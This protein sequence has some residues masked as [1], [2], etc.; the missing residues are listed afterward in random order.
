MARNRNYPPTTIYKIHDYETDRI[1]LDRAKAAEKAEKRR[2][3]KR[4]PKTDAS[5]TDTE[6]RM[7][8]DL[9]RNPRG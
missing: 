8:E 4:T 9:R 5:I 1:S 7:L 6:R 2:P 3:A